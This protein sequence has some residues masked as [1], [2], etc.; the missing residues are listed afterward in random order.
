MRKIKA[1]FIIALSMAIA[2]STAVTGFTAYSYDD[3]K[4]D[5][6]SWT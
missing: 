1:I 4:L 3:S 2:V 6:T 5:D